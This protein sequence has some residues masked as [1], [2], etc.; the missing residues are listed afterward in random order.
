MLEVI[1]A[2]RIRDAVSDKVKELKK[3]K[4]TDPFVNYDMFEKNGEIM[5]DFILS[6]NIPGTN[7]QE[8]VERNVY[9]Y[10]TY[11]DNGNEGVLLFGV[12]ERSYGND[13]G[14]YLLKLKADRFAV[15]NA[16]S[17]FIIPEIKTVK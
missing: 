16:V 11:F 5:L 3:L 8:F 17:A 4:E 12:S 7:E 6:K 2:K 1:T 9:R 15:S 13:I 10:K 14:N